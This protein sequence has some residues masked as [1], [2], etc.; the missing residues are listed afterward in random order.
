MERKFIDDYK[1]FGAETELSV[2]NH[3]SETPIPE[4]EQILHYLKSFPADGIV[5]ST[6]YD[7]VEDVLYSPAVY[8]HFD[9]TYYWDDEETYHFEKYNMK[10]NEDF[11][12]WVLEKVA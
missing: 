1:E 10:L 7:H 5:C 8:T 2:V 11:I 6:L 4:K 12:K 9:G 3:I